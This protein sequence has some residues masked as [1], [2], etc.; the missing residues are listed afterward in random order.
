MKNPVLIERD[1]MTSIG[2][3]IRNK[4]GATTPLK[5][6]QMATAINN[7][8]GGGGDT[9][10]KTVHFIN[11]SM[12]Q[13]NNSLSKYGGVKFNVNIYDYID[14][15]SQI[16]SIHYHTGKAGAGYGGEYPVWMYGFWDTSMWKPID[17]RKSPFQTGYF[18]KSSGNT[19]FEYYGKYFPCA[20]A[21][22]MSPTNWQ[23]YYVTAPI[24]SSNMNSYTPA[25][26]I[27]DDG[28]LVI[29]LRAITGTDNEKYGYGYYYSY[30]SSV[31]NQGYG[32]ISIV[33]K[34]A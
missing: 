27:T 12:T 11:N 4:G 23:T 18:S 3:A 26:C 2:N 34:E 15:V 21:Q 8:S 9:K 10:L 6:G 7:I 20:T 33:Y 16:V 22:A 17:I 5:P 19:Y 13:E 30:S 24:Q 29:A 25:M 32:Y 31:F 14:D 28:K 1:T